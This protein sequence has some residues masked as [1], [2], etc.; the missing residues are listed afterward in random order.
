[1]YYTRWC[2]FVCIN[3]CVYVCKLILYYSISNLHIVDGCMGVCVCM[4]THT[5]PTYSKHTHMY[6]RFYDFL[7][8]RH[9]CIYVCLVHLLHALVCM[10]ASIH[11]CMYASSHACMSKY[12]DAAPPMLEFQS[13]HK[14]LLLKTKQ[15]AYIVK[16]TAVSKVE[17]IFW[18][19]SWITGNLKSEML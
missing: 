10:Y 8:C 12:L 16:K 14:N 15:E 19:T 2:V 13:S 18:L 7:F 9:A 4:H 17:A 11:A 5:Q 3:M 6:T 1:M